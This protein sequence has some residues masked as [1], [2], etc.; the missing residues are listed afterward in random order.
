M[1]LINIGYHLNSSESA[2]IYR[3]AQQQLWTAIGL[4]NLQAYYHL[5]CIYSL[6]DE[7]DKA[8]SWLYQAAHCDVLPAI[9]DMLQDEWLDNLRATS[10][11]VAFLSYL[12]QRG[13]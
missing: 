5:A 7:C 11:F 3:D 8:M 12:E 10:G 1:V 6:L 4:G 13:N 9:D 2:Q